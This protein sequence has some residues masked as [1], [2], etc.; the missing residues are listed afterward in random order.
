VLTDI[1]ALGN[2]NPNQPVIEILNSIVQGASRSFPGGFQ[3]ISYVIVQ[4]SALLVILSQDADAATSRIEMLTIWL[5][6]LTLAL[7]AF[8][9]VLVWQNFKILRKENC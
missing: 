9:S 3:Q 7:L 8:T 4:F 5:C 2:L 6:I 1:G